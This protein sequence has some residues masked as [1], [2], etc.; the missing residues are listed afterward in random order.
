MKKDVL[1]EAVAAVRDDVP[2]D[3]ETAAAAERAWNRIAPQ[4]AGAAHHIRGCADVQALFPAHRRHDLPPARRLLVDDHLAEC[5]PCRVLYAEAPARRLAVLPWRAGATAPASKPH[6]ARR[7]AI[8]AAALLAT[9][10]GAWAV[11]STYFAAPAGS[12][13][14]VQSVSGAL[15]RLS[16]ERAL[17]PGDEIGENEAVRTARGSRAVLRLRDGSLVEMGE[18]AEVS[19]AMRGSDTTIQLARGNIIVQ[20]AKRRTGHLY[21]ASADCTVAVTGTVF[22]VNRGLKGSRVSVLEGQVRVAQGGSEAVLAPG[23][24]WAS[25]EAMGKVPLQEEIAWSGDL[26]RHLKLLAEVKTLREKWAAVPVP[27]VRYESR[28][29]GRLPRATVVFASVPNYGTALAEAHR[30][31]EEQV[32]QSDVLREWWQKAEAEEKGRPSLR[33]V[34]DNV[35]GFSEFLGDEVVVA[36]V[37][38]GPR[39][40][41]A[42]LLVAEEARPGLREFLDREMGARHRADLTVLVRDGIVLVTP[43]RELAAAGGGLD[44]TPFGD[45][46]RAA[47]G[48]GVGILFAADLERITAS[49]GPQRRPDT[50]RQEVLRRTGFDTLSYLVFE[51]KTAGDEVHAQAMLSFKEA[52]RGIPSWL[53]APAPMGSLDFLSPHA[54]IV[55]AGLVKTPSLIFDD[56]VAVASANGPNARRELGELERKL[57]LRL[58]D[59]VTDA[60]GGEVALALDGPLLPT[61]AWKLIVEVYDPARLQASLGTLVQR[62]NDEAVR[63]GRPGLTLEAEQSGDTTYYALLG[64]PV[65][66][67]YA[68]AGGYLVAAPSRALVMKAVQARE[69]GDSLGRSAAFRALFPADRDA[70]VSGLVYQNL[71]RMVGSLLDG[72]AATQLTPEQRQNVQ[73]LAGDARPTLLCAYGEDGGIRVTGMGGLFDL[74]AAELALPMLLQR[75][76]PSELRQRASP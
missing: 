35:R 68:Y 53:A 64:L 28:L 60:L 25:S 37:D 63:A 69:S 61:P 24:Q 47:Y 71:G 36:L 48:S 44:A 42:P 22:S 19:V 56:L 30:I 59:D 8:A 40:G 31:F 20:A 72:P 33:E 75:A 4:A 12:R 51:R 66:L 45:R 32:A 3:A 62:A 55:A 65:E 41:V 43:A 26:D 50:A 10:A 1:D 5:A 13:A 73:A 52:P 17:A 49:T 11:R 54:Q 9:A 29:L 21:V 76:I 57:N 74:D 14:A 18:R 39:T 7:Y 46:I 27:G 15:H 70:H 23:Q 58:R 67:H 6:A 38:A 16:P 2:T 34:V